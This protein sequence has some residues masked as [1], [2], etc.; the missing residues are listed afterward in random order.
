MTAV[1][2]VVYT[3]YIRVL[4]IPVQYTCTVEYRYILSTMT[5]YE[6]SSVRRTEYN[7]HTVELYDTRIIGR[8][9]RLLVL[10]ITADNFTVVFETGTESP[11]QVRYL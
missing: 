11:L 6:Y 9:Q 5:G 10:V 1:L 2:L 7:R 3:I 4:A 8:E